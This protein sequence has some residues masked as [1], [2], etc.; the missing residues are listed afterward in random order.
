MKNTG[1][2]I[3]Q[4]LI[5]FMVVLIVRYLFSLFFG[6]NISFI[7]LLIPSVFAAFAVFF[8]NIYLLSIKRKVILIIRDNN[9]GTGIQ[10]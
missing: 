8:L 5:I 4:L 10:R 6:E 3:F 9:N 7:Y 1:R 2:N